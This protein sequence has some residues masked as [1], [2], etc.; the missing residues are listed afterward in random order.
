MILGQ[1]GSGKTTLLNLLCGIIKPDFGE[2]TWNGASLFQRSA[3]KPVIS[4]IFQNNNLFPHLS[5]KQNIEFPLHFQ[6]LSKKE[7]A[8][9][10]EK[11]IN[12]T[13][14]GNL[15]KKYPNAL[16]GG[17]TQR[18]ALARVIASD[19]EIVFLDEPLSSIDVESKENLIELLRK[20]H[21]TG[22]TII[23]ITH[24]VEETFRLANYLIIMN[25]GAI[26]QQGIMDDVVNHP[27]NNFVAQMFGYF[28]FFE[29]CD[30][31]GQETIDVFKIDISSSPFIIHPSKI[32][33]TT[34]Y[35]HNSIKTSV[36]DISR[37]LNGYYIKVSTN[38]ELTVFIDFGHSFLK[39][40]PCPGM[41]CYI[42][43]KH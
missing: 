10:L 1:S 36:K 13:Q 22:K 40:S 28:N 27:K 41:V 17:E 2:I 3:E 25:S 11:A 16:S 33:I 23:H 29:S 34:D 4:V 14:T 18:V 24:N 26:I 37:T 9:R 32:D 12:A 20:I 35:Q 19:T 39:K 6:K 43:P 7:R 31:F 42:R 5:V 8:N 30:K 21:E 15:L 38:P